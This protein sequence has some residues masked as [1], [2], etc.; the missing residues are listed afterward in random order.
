MKEFYVYEYRDPITKVPFY[1]GKGA[2]RRYLQHLTSTHNKD[3]TAE[4]RRLKEEGL[5]PEIEKVF[6]T[7]NEDIALSVEE[8]LVKSYGIRRKGGLLCNYLDK[9]FSANTLDIPEEVYDLLG[10][11]PDRAVGE[12]TGINWSTLRTKRK[13][14]GIPSFRSKFKG[15]SE[16]G[17]YFKKYQGE[18]VTLFN[19]NGDVLSDDIYSVS[20]KL[21]SSVA[22]IKILLKGGT[23][24]L[25]G[26]YTKRPFGKV[27]KDTVK[28]VI[29]PD[30][31]IYSLTYPDFAALTNNSLSSSSNFFRG[32]CMSLKGWYLNTKDGIAARE[33]ARKNYIIYRWVNDYTGQVFEGRAIDLEKTFNLTS[34]NVHS[35]IRK[36]C[37]CNG[38]YIERVLDDSRVY[39]ED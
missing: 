17:E 2:G 8:H 18:H 5:S 23:K 3:L 10:T 32:Y 36:G 33:N 14:R 28:E 35:A 20:K 29:S 16:L 27:H 31:N 13:N 21:G 26:W 12:V 25:K 30:G 38:W 4:I 1:V 39:C 24:H 11:M 9:C 7:E 37:K 15:K 22:S 19:T 6:F 34:G